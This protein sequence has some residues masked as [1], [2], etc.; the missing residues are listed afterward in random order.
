MAEHFL[1]M[2][3]RKLLLIRALTKVLNAQGLVFLSEF[4]VKYMENALHLFCCLSY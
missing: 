2:Q 4:T 3:L 1:V